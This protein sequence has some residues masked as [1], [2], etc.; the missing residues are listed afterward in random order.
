MLHA[1]QTIQHWIFPTHPNNPTMRF[2][3]QTILLSILLVSVVAGGG[4]E[5]C[6]KPP[7]C[8]ADGQPCKPDK[9]EKCC[10]GVCNGS[11][12]KPVGISISRFLHVAGPNPYFRYALL[13]VQNRV[14][15]ATLQ[16]LEL[17]VH[18]LASTVRLH[19]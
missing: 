9:P 14:A 19:P 11:L 18:S 15:L 4:K 8:K 16:T 5:P 7:M 10:S 2:A 6:H 17:V 1:L 3:I 12:R 13:F